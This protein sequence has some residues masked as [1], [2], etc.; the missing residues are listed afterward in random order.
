MYV[1]P[2]FHFPASHRKAPFHSLSH[3]YL[4]LIVT[5]Y[6]SDN[7]GTAI[8]LTPLSPFCACF[9]IY[10]SLIS[11]SSGYSVVKLATIKPVLTAA[12]IS[13]TWGT[14]LLFARPLITLIQYIEGL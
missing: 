1:I 9:A 4:P 8:T 7:S 3:S 5:L 14:L 12:C 11:I 6:R 2:P 10:C 13:G